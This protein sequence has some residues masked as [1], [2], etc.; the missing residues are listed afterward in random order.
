MQGRS[1]KGGRERAEP[2]RH[3]RGSWWE[4]R[5]QPAADKRLRQR[6]QWRPFPGGRGR[7]PKQRGGR[8]LPLP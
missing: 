6:R 7:A 3:S 4:R 5:R 8:R 1:R 2:L